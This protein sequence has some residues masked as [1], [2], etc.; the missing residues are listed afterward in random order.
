MKLKNNNTTT[1]LGFSHHVL[2]KSETSVTLKQ[3]STQKNQQ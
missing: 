3:G 1:T 2:S